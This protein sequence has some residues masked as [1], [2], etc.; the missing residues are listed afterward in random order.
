MIS[1]VSILLFMALSALPFANAE[2]CPNLSEPIQDVKGNAVAGA[3]V[4]IY[5]A[6]TSTLAQLYSDA[7]CTLV[8]DNP[9]TTGSNGM[10]SAYLPDGTYDVLPVKSGY[11]FTRIEDI[12]KE[13]RFTILS[14]IYSPSITLNRA[15]A[16]RHVLT[17]TNTTAF[18][19][20]APSGTVGTGS[21]LWIVIKNNSGGSVGTITWDSV[22]KKA[23]FTAP[24]NGAQRSILFYWNGTNWV[25]D[26]KTPADVTY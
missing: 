1:R 19:I 26:V 8:I 7:P 22:F 18:T 4:Y 25:E 10:F 14:P 9:V 15:G 16:Q 12:P 17:V 23:S 5:I 3:S 13:D 6:G 21:P 2:A 24:G 11:S 20:Q